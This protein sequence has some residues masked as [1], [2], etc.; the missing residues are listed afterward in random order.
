M[1]WS[2]AAGCEIQ[3]SEE[4]S[5]RGSDCFNE[6]AMNRPLATIVV[7]PRERF[8]VTRRALE[9]LYASTNGA[10]PVVYVDA[11]SPP[12]IRRYLAAQARSRGFELVRIESYLAPNQA[13]N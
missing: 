11:G 9:A 2:T 1:C 3:E 6:S 4:S 10:F 7:V 5:L 8:S 12:A 13:R